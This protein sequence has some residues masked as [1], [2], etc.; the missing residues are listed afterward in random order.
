MHAPHHRE[1]LGEWALFA[2]A[3]LWSLFPVLSR[4]SLQSI[5]PL[6]L[7]ALSTWAA[8]LFFITVVTLQG[9]WRDAT[10]PAWRDVLLTG[11]IIGTAFYALTFIGLRTTTAGNAAL[12]NLVEI[13]T[14]YLIISV[15][16]GHERVGRQQWIGSLALGLGA[17]MI[18]APKVRLAWS[19]GELLILLAVTIV[20]FGNIAAK[21]ARALVSSSWL[22]LVRSTFGAVSLTALAWFYEGS[23]PVSAAYQNWWLIVVNGSVLLGLSKILWMESIHRIPITKSLSLTAIVAPLT[24]LFAFLILREPVSWIQLLAL[25]PM[26]Y[27]LRLLLQKT[28][29]PTI[30]ID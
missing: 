1:R 7:A 12:L 15:W 6:W 25:V 8:V 2:S 23:L 24:L 3:F 14:S 20:P 17:A 22:M 19:S 30:G 5:S 9:T 26:L 21:R 10:Q 13:L 11:L 27:G 29:T 18:L 4:L 28:K 16:L